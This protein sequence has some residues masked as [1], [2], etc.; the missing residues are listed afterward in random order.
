MESD[1]QH[2]F[3]A[4]AAA[5]HQRLTKLL[6]DYG[7]VETI[8]PAVTSLRQR[9]QADGRMLEQAMSGDYQTLLGR[10]SRL[11]NFEINIFEAAFV[12]LMED[13]KTHPGAIQIYVEELLG[14]K[15]ITQP[16]KGRALSSAVKV[17]TMFLN[18]AINDDQ[19]P[20]SP[21]CNSS[22]L[23][24]PQSES[25]LQLLSNLQSR[26]GYAPSRVPVLGA[27][28]GYEHNVQ[29]RNTFNHAEQHMVPHTMRENNL[30]NL[31]NILNATSTAEM[32][33]PR[34]TSLLA[35]HCRYKHTFKMT[36]ASSA[37]Y[38]ILANQLRD[39]TQK[40]IHYMSQVNPG[41]TRLGELCEALEEATAVVERTT[42]G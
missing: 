11:E 39:S 18:L 3:L 13:V 41:D 25:G 42:H 15:A 9:S 2:A 40:C 6:K 31:D 16:L 19:P 17:R 14:L 10:S 21:T 29:L 33:D 28:S 8:H 27:R 24:F 37:G 32:D 4:G 34:L 23:L 12:R 5:A 22:P 36:T 35:E 20:P 38:L 30:P 7:S 26:A 1:L